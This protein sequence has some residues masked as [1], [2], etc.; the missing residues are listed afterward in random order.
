MPGQF[1]VGE[2]IPGGGNPNYYAPFVEIFTFKSKFSPT[3]TEPS[4]FDQERTMSSTISQTLTMKSY[5]Y[6][7]LV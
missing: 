4:N 6:K 1:L 3:R 2:A 7:K 5:L